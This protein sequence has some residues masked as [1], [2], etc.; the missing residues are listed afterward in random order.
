MLTSTIT[1]GDKEFSVGPLTLKQLRLIGMGGAEL[2]NPS[3]KTAGEKEYD[4][5]STTYKII[6]AAT[7]LDVSQIE[8]MVDV[9][10]P[11]LFE[12]QRLIFKI[13]GLIDDKKENN[14]PS[15]EGEGAG[16]G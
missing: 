12:A 16:I 13:T 10:R 11:Q 8:D 9:T 15:G 3:G 4:W 1:L 5:Y 2:A 7:G 6:A 14:T